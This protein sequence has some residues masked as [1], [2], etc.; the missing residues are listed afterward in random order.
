MRHARR[1]W[2]GMVLAAA[3]AL[4]NRAAATPLEASACDS[5]KQEQATLSEVPHLMERGPDWAKSNATPETL[6]RISRWIELTE[7]LTFRCGRGTV[8]AEAKR[9]AAEAALIEN[10][11]PAPTEAGA[12]PLGEA[13]G[14]STATPPAAPS[15]PASQEPSQHAPA[16]SAVSEATGSA[17]ESEANPATPV[18]KKRRKKLKTPQV[19]GEEPAPAAA[20]VEQPPTPTRRA[21]PAT[22][23]TGTESP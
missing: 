18:R 5:A 23:G 2:Y 22:T 17:T 8:T 14:A 4:T 20:S 3:L 15:K 16:V 7:I 21:K 6:S 11:P 13:A 1:V 9:A 12:A 10:P 19:A